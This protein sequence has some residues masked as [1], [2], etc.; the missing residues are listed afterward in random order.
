MEDTAVFKEN[1]NKINIQT[2]QDLNDLRA[3]MLQSMNQKDEVLKQ[4]TAQLD[5]YRNRILRSEYELAANTD[6]LKN[7]SE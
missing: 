5:D 2:I 3:E 7:K 6:T 1:T 4:H